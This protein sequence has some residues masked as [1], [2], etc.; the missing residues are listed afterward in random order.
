MLASSTLI[1]ALLV[2]ASVGPAKPSSYEF[3]STQSDVFKVSLTASESSLTII[4]LRADC[5]AIVGPTNNMERFE[6]FGDRKIGLQF[7]QDSSTKSL[8]FVWFCKNFQ[9]IFYVTKV[10]PGQEDAYILLT[11]SATQK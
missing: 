7:K 2:A 5:D 10:K 11:D 1:T 9:L 4:K 3:N 6:E 8:R